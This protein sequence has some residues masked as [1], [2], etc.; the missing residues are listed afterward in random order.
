MGLLSALGLAT[1]SKLDNLIKEY[2]QQIENIREVL[3]T[4]KT[5]LDQVTREDN[6]I[7]SNL[8]ELISQEPNLS[9]EDKV[10]RALTILANEKVIERD[11]ETIENEAKRLKDQL[12]RIITK[13]NRRLQEIPGLEM[14]LELIASAQRPLQQQ[15]ATYKQAISAIREEKK[16]LVNTFQEY[17]LGQETSAKNTDP[18]NRQKIAKELTLFEQQLDILHS[19]LE[20][21]NKHF[22]EFVQQQRD[23][24]ANMIQ[25]TKSYSQKL[26]KIG[27][28]I[29]QEILSIVDN[30]K[31]RSVIKS[32]QENE[33]IGYYRGPSQTGNKYMLETIRIRSEILKMSQVFKKIQDR[34]QVV[35]QDKLTPEQNELYRKLMDNLQ[36]QRDGLNICEILGEPSA[37]RTKGSRE[38]ILKNINTILI[39]VS[40][41]SK[42]MD[43]LKTSEFSLAQTA[44]SLEHNRRQVS[45]IWEYFAMLL[46]IVVESYEKLEH[47]ATELQQEQ[48]RANFEV[49]MSK[50]QEN[51]S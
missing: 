39:I 14:Q 41:N 15:I 45:R 44:H 40:K 29:I 36:V 47:L 8:H 35:Q 2:T 1:K 26:P 23:S 20:L 37:T 27:D 16:R 43:E 25:I 17:I 5:T 19:N 51:N 18:V 4:T 11:V 9:H 6:K 30:T 13:F 32:F 3:S 50:L 42:A 24:F 7:V 49:L 12:E 31:C 22:K 38:S 21:Q 33:L 28:N 10:K 34:L 46:F 48:T